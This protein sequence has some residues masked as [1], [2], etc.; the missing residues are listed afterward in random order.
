MVIVATPVRLG[1]QKGL[2]V[3]S[4]FFSRVPVPARFYILA[5]QASYAQS[6]A[7]R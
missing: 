3:C 4:G 2:V 5:V 7:L 1:G 6:L